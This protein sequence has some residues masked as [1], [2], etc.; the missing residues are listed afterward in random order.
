MTGG[1][2]LSASNVANFVACGHRQVGA[3]CRRPYEV[4]D[5]KLARSAKARAVAQVGFYSDLL[6]GAQG[7]GAALDGTWRS[8][9][10]S[11][12]R[13]RDDDLTLIAGITAG[14]RRAL[15]G[16]GAGL[17]GLPE[18]GRVSALPCSASST[19]PT[20]T[21]RERRGT[22]RSG[23]VTGGTRS[24]YPRYATRV[25]KRQRRITPGAALPPRQSPEA[26]RRPSGFVR[27]AQALPTARITRRPDSGRPGRHRERA[28]VRCLP[29]EDCAERRLRAVDS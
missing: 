18:L 25:G 26:L 16:M 27:M 1:R 3:C 11:D 2:R 22:P 28:E 19:R 8:A 13:R 9:T 14:Q 4:V 15:K 23:P 7:G 17:A 12:R 10:A 29:R 20:S 6:A 5:A 21:P 24:G